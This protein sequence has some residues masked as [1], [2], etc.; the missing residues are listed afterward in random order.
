MLKLAPDLP[1]SLTLED[2]ARFAIGY[3]HEKATRHG[4]PAEVV[5]DAQDGQEENSDD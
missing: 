5:D 4:K 1:T 2:Q 3:Y